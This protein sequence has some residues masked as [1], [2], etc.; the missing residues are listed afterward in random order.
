MITIAGGLILAALFLMCLPIILG[1]AA[2]LGQVAVG[3]A[4]L[5]LGTVYLGPLGLLIALGINAW[6][7]LS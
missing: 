4:L 6:W 5:F 3:V 1:V 2:V 7:F